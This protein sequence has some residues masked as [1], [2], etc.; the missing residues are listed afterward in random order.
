[1][2]KHDVT[3]PATTL[4]KH[5]KPKLHRTYLVRDERCG[6]E[7]TVCQ[8]IL[9]SHREHD[10]QVFPVCHPGE[11]CNG[12]YHR[13]VAGPDN[14]NPADRGYLCTACIDRLQTIQ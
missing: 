7:F 6:H 13:V 4:A 2:N 14:P 9:E 5:R 12:K 3:T 11:P 8:R 10:K 1:M